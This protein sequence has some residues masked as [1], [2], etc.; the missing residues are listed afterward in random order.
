MVR[1]KL[2]A[3]SKFFVKTSTRA[4]RFY[5]KSLYCFLTRVRRFLPISLNPVAINKVT[6]RGLIGL[7]RT[8]GFLKAKTS[9]LFKAISGLKDLAISL[10]IVASGCGVAGCKGLSGSVVTA[11]DAKIG[12]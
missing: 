1:V 7:E 3:W 5:L 11:T 4:V 2:R 12:F 8:R 6:C 9:L 10:V